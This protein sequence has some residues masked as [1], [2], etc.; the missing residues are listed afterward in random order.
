[1]LE[2]MLKISIGDLVKSRPVLVANF[3]RAYVAVG[4]V[5]RVVD[6]PPH[7]ATWD[8]S[9]ARYVVRGLDGKEL[10]FVRYELEW[11]SLLDYLAVA[12]LS[13]DDPQLR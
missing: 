13:P 4:P 3:E 6:L 2:E 7:V 5:V 10:S 1:M 8:G 12:D 9:P 11:I